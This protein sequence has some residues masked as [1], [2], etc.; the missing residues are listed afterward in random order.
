MKIGTSA[1]EVRALLGKAKIDDKDGFFY[2]MDAEMVQIRLDENEK[3]RL[4]SVTY[5]NKSPNAPKYSDIF[6][7]EPTR[8]KPDGSVYTLVRYPE[9]GYWVAYSKTSG[10][11]P[12]IT[13][14]MQKL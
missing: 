1:D 3:V 12:I 6:G 13:V 14:T 9:A 7:E 5:A 8:A 2:E 4:I 10:D 11:E